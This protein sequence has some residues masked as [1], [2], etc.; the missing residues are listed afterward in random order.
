M[1][2]SH[3]L[4]HGGSLIDWTRAF[5]TSIDE[6]AW[7]VL[8]I[9]FEL[10]TYALSDEAFTR[11]KRILM[12]SLRIICY[13]SLAHTVYAYGIYVV[14]LM[15]ATPIAEVS[16]LC[17]LVGGDLSFARNLL[18]TELDASNCSTLSTAS[19]F[20][21]IDPP[22]FIIVTGDAGL[23]IERQLAWV[24]L[25]EAIVWL[26]ILFTIEATVRLRQ[27]DI[28]EGLIIRSLN[29]AKFLLYGLLWIAIAYWIYRGHWMFA[30]DELIWIAGFIFIEKNVSDWRKEIIDT[31]QA[32]TGTP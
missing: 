27:R 3:T 2:A 1:I 20:F 11:P 10:E 7:F 8:L 26:I 16:N 15:A 4:R 25:L 21:Y 29:S 31:E 23:I 12:H 22:E 5:A 9:L 13:F 19:Q 32:E 30:W 18:Y 6:S 14:E 24:D 28:T 17:Q